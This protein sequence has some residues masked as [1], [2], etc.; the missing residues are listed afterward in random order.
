MHFLWEMQYD[1]LR[2][3]ILEDKLYP[4]DV[5]KA[6]KSTK[7]TVANRVAEIGL[8]INVNSRTRIFNNNGKRVS[9]D[10]YYHEKVSEILR[11][12]PE[13]T[14]K[15]LN[16]LLPGAYA[17][18][19]K[20][21]F[22]WLK[23]RLV[24]EQEKRYWAEWEQKQLE[25]LKDAYSIIQKE[26]DPNRRV[27][28]GWLCTVA[29]VKENEI[30]GRLHRFED[31]RAFIGEVV[32]SKEEWLERRFSGI[33]ERKRMHGEKMSLDDVR[34]EMSLKP[35]TYLKHRVFIEMLIKELNGDKQNES[36]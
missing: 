6:M 12:N 24:T 23:K 32:E 7:K 17:W 1:K 19:S 25:N 34:R 28:I 33:A 15:E 5:A 22:Q 11:S 21:N 29:G 31:I 3:C 10:E 27:T 36:N 2:K 20:N 14:A 16:E 9:A 13:L 30:K 4:P 26:G 35:N 8:D 18:F